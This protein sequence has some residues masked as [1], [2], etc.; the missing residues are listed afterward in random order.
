MRHSTKLWLIAVA[1]MAAAGWATTAHGGTLRL[2]SRAAQSRSWI[3]P[4]AFAQAKSSGLLFVSD[5]NNHVVDIYDL[6]KPTLPI[7]QI[8]G[9]L[10][11][12]GS[13]AVDKS[14]NLFVYDGRPNQV[15]EFKPPY[16]GR[17]LK[18]FFGMFGPVTEL[19]VDAS[20]TLYAAA[21]YYQVF[22]FP[23]GRTNGKGVNLPVSPQGVTLD[24]HGNLIC[25]YNNA[26]A[27]G[28]LKLTNASPLP[29]NLLI[30]LEQSSA[31][32]L[33]DASG[34]LVVEDLGAAYINIYAPESTKPSKTIDDGFVDPV[35]MA[36]DAR[37]HLLVVADYGN[38]TVKGINYPSGTMRWQLTGFAFVWG[39]A[40]SPAAVP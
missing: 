24:S 3:S 39:V 6:K 17:P 8:Q 1:L 30:P 25:T 14:A 31:D 21:Q 28:V 13:L 10:S 36:F 27:A 4:A 32:V 5:Q 33:F 38:N 16:T 12:P 23:H 7:G 20:G 34:N 2:A 19:T 15:L 18:K 22:K 11:L 26:G 37:K 9:P 35:H 40:V 29:T